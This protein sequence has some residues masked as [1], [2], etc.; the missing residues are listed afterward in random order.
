MDTLTRAREAE[1]LFHD[2][3]YDSRARQDLFLRRV[4]QNR[5][6]GN[7]PALESKTRPGTGPEEAFLRARA[8]IYGLLSVT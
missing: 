6:T 3:N 7:A 4:L 5:T 2:E 1:I 8:P